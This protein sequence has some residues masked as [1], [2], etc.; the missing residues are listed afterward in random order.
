[1]SKEPSNLNEYTERYARNNRIEGFGVHGT[2][3]ISACPF[4]AAADWMSC[5]VIE[6][7]EAMTNGAICKKCGRGACAIFTDN[8]NG[9][10]FEIVQTTGPD[11][12]EWL[13]PKMRR[14]GNGG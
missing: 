10:S 13:K 9:V 1:M 4:C 11:Q 12:P 14:I 5:K 3:V 6:T 8:P 2:R 7:R